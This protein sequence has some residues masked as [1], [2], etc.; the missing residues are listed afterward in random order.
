MRIKFKWLMIARLRQRNVFMLKPLNNKPLNP[1]PQIVT[2]V[3]DIQKLTWTSV[4]AFFATV[5]V[6]NSSSAPLSF[7]LPMAAS[8]GNN[9]RSLLAAISIAAI[10]A[11]LK[12]CHPRRLLLTPNPL[13]AEPSNLKNWEGTLGK[14]SSML[15]SS[16]FTCSDCS[17]DVN[18]LWLWGDCVG[19]VVL[20][21]PQ[22]I[23]RPKYG[24]TM[25]APFAGCKFAPNVLLKTI[26]NYC[27]MVHKIQLPGT[28][29]STSTNKNKNK[30]IIAGG[31]GDVSFLTWPK[32]WARRA[33][34]IAA[35]MNLH[36]TSASSSL[37]S[38]VLPRPLKTKQ[39]TS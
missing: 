18:K 28:R 20:S 6:W 17:F 29:N 27:I 13:E 22:A 11:C 14:L 5:P 38:I 12:G 16:A 32:L 15:P 9:D 19:I 31:Y 8:D 33:W 30:K 36:A 24:S 26:E 3:I 34:W 10:T 25:T 21:C 7:V 2:N 37:T 39:Q 1:K 35:S 4:R 23:T